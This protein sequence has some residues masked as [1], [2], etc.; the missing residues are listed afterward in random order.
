ML[1]GRLRLIFS[2]E[3]ETLDFYDCLQIISSPN[4]ELNIPNLI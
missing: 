4:Y 3:I 1:E 2:R